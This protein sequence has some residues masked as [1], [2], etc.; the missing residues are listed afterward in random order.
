MFFCVAGL[1][2]KPGGYGIRSTSTLVRRGAEAI[3]HSDAMDSSDTR[4]ASLTRADAAPPNIERISTTLHKS[5]RPLR[6]TN[7]AIADLP[8]DTPSLY[9]RS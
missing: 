1:E 4:D 8:P 3:S 7:R 9:E 2:L 5:E 6:P